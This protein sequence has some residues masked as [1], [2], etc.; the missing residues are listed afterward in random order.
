M[1]SWIL[2]AG[3]LALV[4]CGEGG[5]SDPPARA[6]AP[7]PPPAASAPGASAP[8]A[9][10]DPQ[11]PPARPVL[12]DGAAIFRTRCATCHGESGDGNGALAGALKPPPRDFRQAAWQESVSDAHIESVISQGGPSVGL[13]P[14]MPAHPDLNAGQLASL[15]AYVRSLAR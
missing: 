10:P 5:S 9:A 4:A 6:P 15:R 1:R 2:L 14:I 11:T 13:S 8:P 7:V 12:A 3:A